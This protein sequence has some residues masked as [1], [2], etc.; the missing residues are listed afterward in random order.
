VDEVDY[1]RW[2]LD[3]DRAVTVFCGR[4]MWFYSALVG[5]HIIL[6]N[7][8]ERH[9]QTLQIRRV[10][11]KERYN[12]IEMVMIVTRERS[13]PEEPRTKTS[14]CVVR[15]RLPQAQGS[16]GQRLPRNYALLMGNSLLVMFS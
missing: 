7:G 9:E 13:D 4:T 2:E 1:N 8:N 16:Y 3:Q 14:P 6:L 15:Y 12:M 5:V 11:H 10:T